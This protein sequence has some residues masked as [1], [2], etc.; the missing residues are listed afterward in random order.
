MKM[1]QFSLE[2]FFPAPIAGRQ[3]A[4]TRRHQGIPGIEILPSGRLFAVWYGGE[5]AGEGPGN[6]VVLAVSTDC[7]RSWREIQVVAPP[8]SA[9]V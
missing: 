9:A 5:I 8:A 6:Y 4:G 7:G 3:S 2:P 1:K